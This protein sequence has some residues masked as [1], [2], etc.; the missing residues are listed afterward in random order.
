MQT[1]ED[2]AHQLAE[3]CQ[4][5]GAGHLFEGQVI[6]Q[7]HDSK[8][9]ETYGK[10]LVC[11]ADP[12]VAASRGDKFKL[13]DPAKP[14]AKRCKGDLVMV[15]DT[16]IMP[17]EQFAHAL[18]DSCATEH[19]CSKIPVMPGAVVSGMTMR[20]KCPRCGKGFIAIY[21]SRDGWLPTQKKSLFEGLRFK[22]SQ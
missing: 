21:D 7:V 13:I 8:M 15:D 9:V 17:P 1:P 6:T 10:C 22:G 5:N 20:A 16:K 3:T 11:G 4:S 2:F 18:M 12:F 19:D 14:P